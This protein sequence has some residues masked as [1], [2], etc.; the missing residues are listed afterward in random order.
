MGV[1]NTS[2]V[3]TF[4]AVSDCGSTTGAKKRWDFGKS[5]ING[6]YNLWCHGSDPTFDSDFCN[7][8]SSRKMVF[9]IFFGHIFS[10]RNMFFS[11]I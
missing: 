4:W 3:N 8:C 9:R 11:G 1:K 5:L 7:I 6:T 10:T 2:E